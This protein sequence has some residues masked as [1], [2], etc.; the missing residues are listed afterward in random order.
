MSSLDD[1]WPRHNVLADCLREKSR[2]RD[3]VFLYAASWFP[4]VYWLEI[5][6]YGIM[7]HEGYHAMR[8]WPVPSSISLR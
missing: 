7:L 8:L 3:C 6:C 2:V 4:L 1:D 5:D